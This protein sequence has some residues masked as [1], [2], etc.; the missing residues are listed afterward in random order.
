MSKAEWCCST[1][2]GNSWFED[3]YFNVPNWQRGLAYMATRVSG[4]HPD[5]SAFLNHLISTIL[6]SSIRVFKI[7]D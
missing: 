2:D 1:G 6:S 4:L 3:T 5:L 7:P